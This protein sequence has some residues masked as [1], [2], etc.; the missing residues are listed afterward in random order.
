MFFA[1]LAQILRIFASVIELY[2]MVV[3]AS[4]LIS[5]VNPDPYNPVVRTIRQLTEP[6]LK[7]FRRFLHR[8]TVQTNIDFSPML[9]FV[10]LSIMLTM[11]RYMAASLQAGN[12]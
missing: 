4:V 7:P 8:L 3:I 10:A 6:A 11:M 2:Q 9:L 12:F 1:V 5:W